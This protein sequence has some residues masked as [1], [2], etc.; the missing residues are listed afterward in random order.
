MQS[1]FLGS[2]RKSWSRKTKT[3]KAPALYDLTSLC[4]RDANR[5]LGFTAQQTLDGTLQPFY[6]KEVGNV[7]R[8]DSR[9]LD[10]EGEGGCC[11]TILLKNDFNPKAYR[12]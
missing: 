6:V 4:Q 3:E 1:Q 8:T 2:C 5:I 10:R 11:K 12:S 7:P 9:Y